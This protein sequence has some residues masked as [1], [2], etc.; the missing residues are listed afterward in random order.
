V[1]TKAGG[2]LA[3]TVEAQVVGGLLACF[4]SS[5]SL[6]MLLLLLLLPMLGVVVV[7][8]AV[9]RPNHFESSLMSR[10]FSFRESEAGKC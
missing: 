5:E 10:V 4:C 8:V 2:R 1:G 9:S 6:S 7:V 3:A